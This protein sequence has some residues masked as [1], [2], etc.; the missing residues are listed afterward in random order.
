MAKVLVAYATMA[1]S[2]AEV[3]QGVAKVLTSSGHEVDVRPVDSVS[4]LEGYQAVV[5]GAPMILGW[6]R[7]GR[8]FLHHHRDSLRTRPFAVFA[9]AMSLTQTG[10]TSLDGVPV[11]LDEKL[12]KAPRQPGR[13]TIRERYTNP[14]N[15]AG[16]I[17]R[18]SR[19]ARP[20]SLAFFGGRLN[21][22]RLKWWAV[23]FALIIVRAQ[24]GDRR[25]WPAIE[26]WASA[27]SPALG[28]KT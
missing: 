22:G 12:A 13:L 27:L 11:L 9:T 24:A 26:A 28:L 25:N 4:D 5:V 19:P 17:F 3:A 1:G 8:R 21:F 7:A 15:Y 23:L 20:V 10:V 14:A 2:T 16:P 6:H 18:A